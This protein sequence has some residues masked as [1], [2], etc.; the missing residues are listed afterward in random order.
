VHRVESCL[1]QAVGRGSL[2]RAL[3]ASLDDPEVSRLVD[4]LASGLGDER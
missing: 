3:K 1:R 2:A 4:E